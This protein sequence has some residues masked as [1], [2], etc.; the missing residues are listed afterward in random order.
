MSYGANT[1]INFEMTF[2]VEMDLLCFYFMNPVLTF[3]LQNLGIFTHN[4]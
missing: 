2:S 1:D 4:M 3:I